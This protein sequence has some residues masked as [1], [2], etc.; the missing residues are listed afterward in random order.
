MIA[1]IYENPTTFTI[2]EVVKN[3]SL[4]HSAIPGS[5]M[6]IASNMVRRNV[7]N[8]NEASQMSLDAFSKRRFSLANNGRK[9]PTGSAAKKAPVVESS[10]ESSSEEPVKSVK[11]A[12]PIKTTATPAKKVSK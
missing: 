1:D 4:D 10:D 11:K 2:W 7:Y 5:I 9:R 6:N 3:D 12:A 8:H